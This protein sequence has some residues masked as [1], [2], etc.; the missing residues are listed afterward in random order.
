MLYAKIT[1]SD[2]ICA[3]IKPHSDDA[4]ILVCEVQFGTIENNQFKQTSI[5]EIEFTDFE[6]IQW[7]ID[8]SLLLTCAAKKLNV[9]ILEII[10][11]L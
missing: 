10:L 3:T 7:D 4:P 6:S 5:S 2:Y 9:A 11:T 8:K 1:T